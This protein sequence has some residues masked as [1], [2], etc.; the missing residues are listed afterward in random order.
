MDFRQVEEFTLTAG[1]T[2]LGIAL[3]RGLRLGARSAILLFVLFAITFVL[4]QPE[5]RFWLAMIYLALAAVIFVVRR[6]L[7]LPALTEPFRLP[8]KLV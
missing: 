4:P 2:L 7:I 8:K 5:I 1:Q 3:L 6:K